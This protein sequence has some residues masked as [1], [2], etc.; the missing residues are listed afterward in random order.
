MV[1]EAL[2]AAELNFHAG[3]PDQ[4]LVLRVL[5]KLNAHQV[6][7]VATHGLSLAGVDYKRVVSL[8]S[9]FPVLCWKQIWSPC[10][11]FGSGVTFPL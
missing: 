1:T 2:L 6:P 8:C 9:Q 4:L 10:Y 11:S 7:S 5:V 3:F